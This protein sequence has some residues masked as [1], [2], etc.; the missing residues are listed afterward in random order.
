MKKIYPVY[1]TPGNTGS[2]LHWENVRIHEQEEIP[3]LPQDVQ[4]KLAVLMMLQREGAIPGVGRVVTGA[5]SGR[6]VA[7]VEAEMQDDAVPQE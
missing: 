6:R 5:L 1:L 7:V 3:S 4:E 2:G